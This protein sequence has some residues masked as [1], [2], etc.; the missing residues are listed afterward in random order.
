MDKLVQDELPDVSQIDLIMD[1]IDE[2]V[3]WITER[4]RCEAKLRKQI[5]AYLE[6]HSE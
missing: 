6:K 1:K 4:E 3:G 2:I 5:E